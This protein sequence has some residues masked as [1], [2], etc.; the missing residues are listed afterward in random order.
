MRIAARITLLIAS[1]AIS[2][3][4]L[5]SPAMADPVPPLPGGLGPP[6]CC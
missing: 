6:V 4:C 5:G 3:S 2:L 1:V